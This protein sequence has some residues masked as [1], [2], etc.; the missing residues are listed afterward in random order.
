MPRF[1]PEAILRV[2]R[3]FELTQN[4][5]DY[6]HSNVI[7]RPSGRSVDHCRG[8]INII[9][10]NP[11]PQYW[12]IDRFVSLF[13]TTGITDN[14]ARLSKQSKSAT[15]PMPDAHA[16]ANRSMAKQYLFTAEKSR[17]PLRHA[18][19]LVSVTIGNRY[20]GIPTC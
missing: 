6:Y 4:E 3:L 2:N 16:P 1:T 8:S 10:V 11:W 15:S 12:F 14:E 17:K 13:S 7:C 20:L 18:L 5:M 19:W 9:I